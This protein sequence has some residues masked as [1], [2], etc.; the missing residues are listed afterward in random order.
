M[1]PSRGLFFGGSAE[2]RVVLPDPPQIGTSGR[3]SRRGANVGAAPECAG[4]AAERGPAVLPRSPIGKV[5]AYALRNRKG[6]CRYA[7]DGRLR[8]DSSPVSPHPPK[9]LVRTAATS[10]YNYCS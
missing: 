2:T 3:I 8:S 6:L 7:G 1:A 9:A 5:F 10:G 4:G